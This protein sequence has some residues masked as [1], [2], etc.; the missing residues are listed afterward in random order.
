MSDDV[1][2]ATL[3]LTIK[4]GEA[5][6]NTTIKVISELL[7]MLQRSQEHRMQMEKLNGTNPAR[8]LNELKGGE[9]KMLD[10]LK[11]ARKSGDTVSTLECGIS[12]DDAKKIAEMAKEYG[13]PVAFTNSKSDKNIHLN[14]RSSDSKML[15]QMMS[16]L[17]NDKISNQSQSIGNFKVNAWEIPYLTNEL[18][19]YNLNA[20]FGKTKDGEYFCMFEKAD[21]KALLIARG[22]F[23]RKYNEVKKDFIVDK[24]EEGFFT[25][26][27]IHSGKEISFDDTKKSYNELTKE[28]QRELG[29]DENKAAIAAAKFGEENFEGEIKKDYFSNPQNETR[30]FVSNITFEDDDIYTIP[31]NCLRIVPKEDNMS[32]IVFASSEGR[33]AVIDPN[34]GRSEIENALKSQLGIDDAK[35][36]DSL[37]SKAEKA[38]LHYDIIDNKEKYHS[39]YSF[40]KSD[41]NMSD[42]NVVSNLKREE[43]GHT[44]TRSLP[45]DSLEIEI[46]RTGN[47][48]FTVHSSAVHAEINE[49]QKYS[50]KIEKE[51]ISCGFSDKKK[52]I[53]ELEQLFIAQGI[54][55]AS[56]ERA[57]H[58]AFAK[59]ESQ[60]IERRA[61]I[62]EVKTSVSEYYSDDLAVEVTVLS[63]GKTATIDI[64]DPDKSADK[65]AAAFDISDDKAE[66]M[67]KNIGRDLSA[68]QHETLSKRGYDCDDWTVAEASYVIGKIAKNG[69]EIPEGM[70]PGKFDIEDVRAEISENIK[71]IGGR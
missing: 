45:V 27:D 12:R 67:V 36:L 39:E 58:D 34:M 48:R 32:R 53:H 5:A 1:A 10:L 55:E 59:A 54:P 13:V 65:L 24:D 44:Y 21:Q 35:E 61:S 22:E 9:V 50:K 42:L 51:S 38:I 16:D 56:A 63:G 3:N 43:D 23:I 4:A 2:S 15:R 19:K 29:Y 60:E 17:M 71:S 25:L 28:I 37:A 8:Y 46:D 57:A 6:I 52:A 64:T 31:Y 30:D 40:N 18:N 70:E 11:N 33:F 20:Q 41:F 66:N 62:V 68:R 69:W 49:E 14:V 7:N 26:K 47:D